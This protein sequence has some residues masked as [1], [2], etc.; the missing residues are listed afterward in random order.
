M[1]VR[2]SFTIDPRMMHAVKCLY[3]N[4]ET[5]FG[6][7][8]KRSEMSHVPGNCTDADS[9]WRSHRF[10]TMTAVY[11]REQWGTPSQFHARQ[12]VLIWRGVV[13]AAK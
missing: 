9:R 4:G 12:F 7:A 1:K 2:S 8:T 10:S 13:I 5:W 6:A 3:F 11:R